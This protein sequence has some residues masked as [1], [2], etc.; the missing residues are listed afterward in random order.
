MIKDFLNKK[1]KLDPLDHIKLKDLYFMYRSECIL[2]KQ[3][4]IG[5]KTFARLIRKFYI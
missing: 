3:V 5:S 1:T 2:K 4:P